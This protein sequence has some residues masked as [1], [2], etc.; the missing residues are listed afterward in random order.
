MN[1][2]P[3]DKI[4]IPEL[5]LES[6]VKNGVNVVPPLLAGIMT[7]EIREMLPSNIHSIK[8]Q[9]EISFNAHIMYAI[10]SLPELKTALLGIQFHSHILTY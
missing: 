3:S 2:E 10:L 5:R 1:T 8:Q 9:K 7:T 6:I 4:D